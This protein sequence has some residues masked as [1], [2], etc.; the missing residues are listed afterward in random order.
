MKVVLF[1]LKGK[2][3]KEYYLNELCRRPAGN[4]KVLSPGTLDIFFSQELSSV[5]RENLSLLLSFP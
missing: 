2:T 3:K 4:R 5:Q 1:K